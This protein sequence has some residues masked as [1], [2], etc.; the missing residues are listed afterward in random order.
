MKIIIAI[1][2]FKGCMTSRQAAKAVHEGVKQ[3]CPDAEVIELPVSDGGE[4][5]LEAF[6]AALGGRMV[7]ITVHDPLMRPIDTHYG[8]SPN[9]TTAIIEM[10]KASGLTLLSPSERNPLIATTYGTGEMI[11]HAIERGCKRIIVGLGGS[12]TCDFGMGMLEAM[13]VTFS[14][15]HLHPIPHLDHFFYND[16]RDVEVVVASD[17]QNPLC[18][19]Q[20][21]AHVF[22]RQKGASS[23]DIQ[24]LDKRARG[25]QYYSRMV[26]GK[27]M[28]KAPGA[29]AAGG[30]GYALMEYLDA[31]VHSGIDLLLDVARFDHLLADAQLVITGEGSADRQTLMGKLPQGV[32]LRAAAHHVPTA[33]VAG[34]VSDAPALLEAGF[35]NVAGINPP[36]L[37]LAEC[38]KPD[39]ATRNLA[40]T[41]AQIIQSI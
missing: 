25:F 13:G 9:G 5:M 16:H 10:A 19:K 23:A 24:L 39:V 12:A 4:G 15:K 34:Q 17:V 37:P 32:M 11:V 18:G 2:S 7:P 33:L 28:A 27:N 26:L 8:I 14:D 36:D 6:T 40:S 1:D 29:G 41:V 20:G 22:A 3:A 38:L 21:A 35:A 31:T 30:L